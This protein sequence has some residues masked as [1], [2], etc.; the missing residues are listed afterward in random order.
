MQLKKIRIKKKFNCKKNTQR[1]KSE[2]DVKQISTKEIWRLWII[3]AN[4]RY[5]SIRKI[6]IHMPSNSKKWKN[7]RHYSGDDYMQKYSW[8]IQKTA[9]HFRKLIMGYYF[10]NLLIMANPKD[11]PV[12]LDKQETKHRQY[13]KFLNYTNLLIILVVIILFIISAYII[14]KTGSLESTRLYNNRLS[15]L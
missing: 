14:F 9:N 3:N 12:R 10:L 13:F 15:W 11:E 2:N 5:F 4:A 1:K 7:R 6:R 8:I